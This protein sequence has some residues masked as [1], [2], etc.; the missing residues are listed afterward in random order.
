MTNPTMRDLF[1]HPRNPLRVKEA[2]LSLL[3]GDIYGAHA[4]L[5]LA[6]AVQGDLLHDLARQHRAAR[7]RAWRARRRNI[8]Q[9]GATKGRTCL[10]RAR[11]G[12]AGPARA[13]WVAAGLA[14]ALPLAR[15]DQTAVGGGPGR[16]CLRLPHYRGS[17]QSRNWVLPV[18]YVVY[19]GDI[20]K[21]DRDGARAVLFDTER[22][23]VDL[24]VA[25]TAP[26]R[27]DD[28]DARQGMPD[29]AAT[30]ELGPNLNFTLGAR[31]RLEARTCALPVRAA[32]TL[33][34]DPQMI[35]WLAT[36]QLEP[37][38][39]STAGMPRPAGRSGVRQPQLQ[40]LLLRRRARSSPRRRGRAITR[41]AASA[42]GA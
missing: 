11:P 14:G 3:A 7:W 20:I 34:S 26:T 10:S 27:S 12:A 16:R 37:R 31:R 4:D 41:P 19:R 35:G 9:V 32:L 28:N 21:A 13:V 24:S 6:V 17:D 8:Q 5:G 33:E 40:R 23:D 38:R 36:P 22:F 39:R 25:A 15:A 18:P 1:M 2:L 42:A 29:L 30:F